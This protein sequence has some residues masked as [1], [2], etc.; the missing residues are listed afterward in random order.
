MR[1]VLPEERDEA[2]HASDPSRWVILPGL[3]CQAA[4]GKLAYTEEI[5]AAWLLLFTAAHTVDTIE[6]GDQDSKIDLLGG[7]GAAINTANG[8]FL[9][10]VQLLVSMRNGKIP[11]DLVDVLLQDYLDTIL[12]M[13][14]GQHWDLTL[15][16]VEL[17]QWWQVAEAKSGAFFSLACRS[18]ARLGNTD[19]QVIE[20][21]SKYGYYLGLLLQILDD[22]EDFQKFTNSTH[23]SSTK[24]L[25][26]SLAV[27][28]ADSVLSDAE[29]SE[30]QQ[31][32]REE[33]ADSESGM[34]MLDVLDRCG[35]GLYLLAEIDK[36]AGLALSELN[37][38]QP[39]QMAGRKLVAIIEAM[40]PSAAN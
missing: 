16:E 37:A 24:H 13:T 32:L 23:D 4:G 5:S 33:H 2:E 39:E 25:E 22:L 1:V 7:A 15:D 20:H 19:P 27:A 10:A 34:R 40:K 8:L 6:D 30:L 3:C 28:Y 35:A 31:I 18:G 26:K 38:A 9:S 36:Y 21:Y 11:D 29:R 14:S 17:N 12:V